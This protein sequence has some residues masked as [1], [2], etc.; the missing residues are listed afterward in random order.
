MMLEEMVKAQG[1]SGEAITEQ[2]I[3]YFYNNEFK[4][5]AEVI[6]VASPNSTVT[7]TVAHEAPVNEVETVP[8]DIDVSSTSLTIIATAPVNKYDSWDADYVVAESDLDEETLGYEL[9]YNGADEDIQNAWSF[10]PEN[11]NDIEDCEIL[12]T[13]EATSTLEAP[14]FESQENVVSTSPTPEVVPVE[15]LIQK[16]QTAAS[17]QEICQALKADDECKQEAWDVL[18]KE[19]RKRITELTPPGVVKLNNAK[20]EGLIAEFRIER[21]DVYHA[22]ENGCFIWDVVFEYRVDEYLAR[23]HSLAPGLQV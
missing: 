8:Q 5:S 9:D 2:A 21:E 6:N 3:I 15:Q 10:E 7:E 16:L 14:H 11:D 23:L 18:T 19:E 17:W 13:A 12:T 22:R 20:R 1:K 4:K